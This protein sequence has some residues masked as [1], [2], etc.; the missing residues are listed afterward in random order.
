MSKVNINTICRA[1][2][3]I[4]VCL[5]RTCAKRCRIYVERYVLPTNRC[6]VMSG[7]SR[8]CHLPKVICFALFCLTGLANSYAQ[9]AETQFMRRANRYYNAVMTDFYVVCN[10][11]KNRHVI[12]PPF[13]AR[14]LK[15]AMRHP[16]PLSAILGY[17]TARTK[18]LLLWMLG[19]LPAQVMVLVIRC[20]MAASE[21]RRKRKR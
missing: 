2:C 9:S 19:R 8:V 13:T 7:F 17:R 11:L 18:N 16:A 3:L 15:A 12:Q 1:L 6:F 5:C 21:W 14:E 20:L 4:C 10:I